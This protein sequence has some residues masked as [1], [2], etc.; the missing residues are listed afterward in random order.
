MSASRPVRLVAALLLG[1]GALWAPATASA[2]CVILP[3]GQELW[4][5]ADA[6]FLGTVT[7]VEN[8]ARWAKVA[9][10]EVWN[11]PDQP[12]EVIVRGGPEDP[13]TA[14][15]VDRTYEVG[16]SYLFAVSI[17]D[18]NLEDN[19]CSGTTQADLMDIDRVRPAEVREPGGGGS[20]TGPT[21]A[22]DGLDLG[23]LS[24]PVLVVAVVGGVLLVIVLLA[25]RR[26]A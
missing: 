26:E 4:R 2:S 11:G 18:G 13:G 6:V 7:A 20:G 17:V 15:S 25:R 10:E 19:A 1:L 24:G 8:N 9:V 12:A 16:V 5:T 23:A 14:S 21:D 3:D 22:A